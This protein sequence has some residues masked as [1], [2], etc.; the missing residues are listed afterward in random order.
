MASVDDQV[1]TRVSCTFATVWCSAPTG[2]KVEIL[3]GNADRLTFLVAAFLA[4]R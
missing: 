1:S 2:S 4:V 3:S